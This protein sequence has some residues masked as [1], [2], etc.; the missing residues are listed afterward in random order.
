MAEC[1][2]LVAADRVIREDN[3]KFS[4]IGMFS[5]LNSGQFPA[6]FAPWHIFAHL[7]DIPLSGPI[8]LTVSVYNVETTLV[9]FSQNIDVPD[10]PRKG[11]DLDLN[12]IIT[13]AVFQKPGRHAVSL[14]MNK[15]TLKIL[16]LNVDQ[17]GSQK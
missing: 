16:Y 7:V 13:N 3:G 8:S 17:I 5:N 6:V 4:I 14:N 12:L 1:E 15:N 11:S 9:S 10:E 2:I